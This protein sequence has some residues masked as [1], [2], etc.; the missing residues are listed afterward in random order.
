MVKVCL[1]KHP[2]TEV[3]GTGIQI[4]ISIWATAHLPHP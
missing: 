1:D 3:M 2:A 4:N